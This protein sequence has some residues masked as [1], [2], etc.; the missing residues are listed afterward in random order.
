MKSIPIIVYILL[1]I[2]AIVIGVLFCLSGTSSF[3]GKKGENIVRRIIGRTN[4]K[5]D[6]Y[7]FNNYMLFI[8]GKSCQ[9]DHI[10]VDRW[11]V[12]VIETKNYSGRIYGSEYQK[13]WT[14]VLSR[15]RIKNKFYNPVKQ[16]A[17]H[18][19][20]LKQILPKDTKIHSAIVFVQGNTQYIDCPN[21]RIYSAVQLERYLKDRKK[22][23]PLPEEGYASSQITEINAILERK[24]ANHLISSREHVEEI[25]TMLDNIEKNICPRCGGKLVLRQGKYGDFYGCENYPKCRF[26]KNIDRRQSPRF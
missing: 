12:F 7:V 16:N 14:Q 22:R 15:G 3:K 4:A 23:S 17:T 26:K 10:L 5:R 2:A 25:R 6:I 24:R 21:Q 1:V 18:I 8:D 20:A 9:I 11:G 19:Y 13:E